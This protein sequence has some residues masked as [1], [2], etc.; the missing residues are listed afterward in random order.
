MQLPI[1]TINAPPA[2]AKS[3]NAAKV[4]N[5][6][7]AR[8][9]YTDNARTWQ[10]YLDLMELDENKLAALIERHGDE[11]TEPAGKYE[12][13]QRLAAVFNLIPTI[14]NMFVGYLFSEEPQI[15]VKADKD[16]A[17]F[18][19]DC[20]GAGMKLPDWIRLKALPYAVGLGWLDTLVQNP[21]ETPQPAAEGPGTAAAPPGDRGGARPALYP[22]TPLHRI[23]W[24][25]NAAGGLNW[26][27]FRDH[28]SENPDP[29]ATVVTAPEAYITVSA[30]RGGVDG[31]DPAH[32]FWA[33]VWQ[34][35]RAAAA[36]ASGP[37]GGTDMVWNFD[38]DWTPVKRCAVASLFYKESLD[39][40][41][42]AIG[43]SKLGTI[44]VL[45]R[46]I[47]NVLSWTEEDILANLAL[48]ALP[49]KGGVPPKDE[50]GNPIQP[51]LSPSTILYWNPEVGGEPMVIQGEVGHI[52]VKMKF[53]EALTTEILRQA[54]LLGVTGDVNAV[55]SGVQGWVMRSELFQ[56]LSQMAASLDAYVYDLFALAK[57]WATN[58]DWTRER[59][60]KEIN[61]TVNFHKGPY[62]LD[63]LET[64]IANAK[65]AV[66]LFKQVSPKMV[67]SAL[68]YAARSFL[69]SDDPKL[70]EVLAEITQN[71]GGLLETLA[72][73]QAELTAAA[74]AGGK[75]PKGNS[76]LD[77]ESA[78]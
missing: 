22:I 73:Q 10:L 24:S 19:A 56:E 32:G 35:T 51:T 46:V 9:E 44:A 33:R 45:T 34:G 6:T 28:G 64:V 3:I 21:G 20:N 26:L 17:A 15:D 77:G 16:L 8:K 78:I 13:R 7:T 40:K 71:T 37:A 25:A 11:Q 38:A 2:I 76:T 4:W 60:Q 63:P 75:P 49:S 30:A 36:G 1:G 61:P 72:K 57:S 42:R 18:L 43:V 27:T 39:P 52:E 29:F 48:L 5:P 69:Y 50:H 66:T 58:E 23:N 12:T 65:E 67:E 54:N 55:T 62:T 14:V 41:R 53:V 31:Y 70:P 59:V 47:I 68:A 74:A